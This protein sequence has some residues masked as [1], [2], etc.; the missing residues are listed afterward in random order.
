VDG[1]ESGGV[2]WGVG[3]RLERI[4]HFGYEVD[5]NLGRLRHVENFPGLTDSSQRIEKSMRPRSIRLTKTAVSRA[6]PGSSTP[7]FGL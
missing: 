4:V 1:R 6:A 7:S 5:L 2:S 3:G